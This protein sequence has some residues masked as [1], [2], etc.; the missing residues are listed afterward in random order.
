MLSNESGEGVQTVKKDA[1]ELL[2]SSR[3]E[4]K[5]E[6]LSGGIPALRQE[7]EFLQGIY[8]ARPKMTREDRPP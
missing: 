1:C 7:E 4:T 6:A 2:L 8:V 3:L 5:P